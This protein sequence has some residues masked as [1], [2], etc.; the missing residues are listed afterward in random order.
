MAIERSEQ[1][2]AKENAGGVALTKL[3]AADW[4]RMILERWGFPV[5]VA[6]ALMYFVRMD[7]VLPMVDAHVKFLDEMT[8]TQREIVQTM[9]EQTRLL[10]ALQP[11]SVSYKST[12]DDPQN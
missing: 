2:A 7:L 6:L 10:Y 9:R 1:D 4:A 11:Q 8:S 12:Q 5:L 3:E